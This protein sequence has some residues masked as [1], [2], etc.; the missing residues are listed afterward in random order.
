MAEI[1]SQT[2][3]S[4][5]RAERVLVFVPREERPRESFA[6]SPRS[7]FPPSYTSRSLL[8]TY[9]RLNSADFSSLVYK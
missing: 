7:R 2:A 6:A 9:G 4:T 1:S 8:S 5:S 3:R